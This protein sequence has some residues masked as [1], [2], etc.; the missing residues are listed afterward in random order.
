MPEDVA[1][2]LVNA[3]AKTVGKEGI[4]CKALSLLY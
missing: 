1:L 2:T 3:I 4:A